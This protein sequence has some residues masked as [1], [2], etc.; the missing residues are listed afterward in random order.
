MPALT[1]KTL[2]GRYIYLQR[3]VPVDILR[4]TTPASREAVLGTVAKTISIY[5]GTD[6]KFAM[7]VGC[8]EW[9]RL[10]VLFDQLRGKELPS[11]IVIA[12]KDVLEKIAWNVYTETKQGLEDHLHSLVGGLD[13]QMLDIAYDAYTDDWRTGLT[14]DIW[15]KTTTSRTSMELKAYG[16]DIQETSADFYEVRSLIARAMCDAHKIVIEGLKGNHLIK[17]SIP[18]RITSSVDPSSSGTNAPTIIDLYD[19][20][21]AERKP[22]PQTVLEWKSSIDLFIQVVGGNI[23]IIDVTGDNVRDYKDMLLLMPASMS[24]RYHNQSL[25]DVISQT[26]GQDIQR[27]SSATVNKYLNAVKAIFSWGVDNRYLAVNPSNKINVSTHDDS[28]ERLP[29]KDDDLLRIF[30]STIFT[31][32]VRPKGGGGEASYWLPLMALYTGCRL[33]ELGQL[34]VLDVKCEDGINY[35]DLNTLDAGKSLKNKGSRRSVPLHSELI[36]LGLLKYVSNI[37]ASKEARLFPLLM[38]DDNG[39]VTASFSKWFGRYKAECGIEAPSRGLKDFHSFR[40]T[41]KDACR[42]VEISTE[43]HNSLTG[44]SSGDVGS[45]YG[46]GVS[47]KVKAENINKLSYAVLKMV[48]R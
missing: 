14:E 31:D 45:T 7:K 20:Y 15:S 47:L 44:H 9:T 48:G 4:S 40:H 42:E 37:R 24:K 29:F 33:E 28:K 36:R 16:V 27:I 1:L 38:P 41:F 3:R 30:G 43:V 32:G 39:K 2:K 5:L 11:S 12:A 18:K 22:K 10:E 34:H 13:V 6:T 17:P 26:K 23:P 35:I 8:Q 19:K 21:I 25:S 46:S